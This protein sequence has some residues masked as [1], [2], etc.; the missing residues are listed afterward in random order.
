MFANVGAKMDAG[1]AYVP[2]TT[3]R[4]VIAGVT[5][6]GLLCLGVL[7]GSGLRDRTEVRLSSQFPPDRLRD[8]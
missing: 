7:L 1:I 2:A 4:R 8:H 6:L 3:R 5:A